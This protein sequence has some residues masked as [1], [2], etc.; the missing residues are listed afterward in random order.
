MGWFRADPDAHRLDDPPREAA[1]LTERSLLP[2]T[3]VADIDL[4]VFCAYMAARGV[5][6]DP[7][8][9]CSVEDE[10]RHGEVLGPDVIF[11]HVV[12]L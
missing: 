4:D 1:G 6:H 5:D 10:L 2:G 12:D 7:T 8:G 3:S 11:G 9:G